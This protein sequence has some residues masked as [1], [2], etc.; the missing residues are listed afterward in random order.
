MLIKILP[1]PFTVAKIPHSAPIPEGE[2]VF[3]GRT[4]DEYS[5]LCP[6]S[7]VPTDT[8][9]REDG[10]RGMR[11]AGQLDFSLIGIL[12]KIS[13]V[14]AQAKI[15]IFA[16]STFDTDYIFV[17]EENLPQA[18]AALLRA[19]YDLRADGVEIGG[20]RV[21]DLDA[22]MELVRAVRGNFP[23]LET[24]DALEEHRQTVL[25]FIRRGSAFCARADGRIVGVLLFSPKRNQ[26]CCMAVDPAYR[27]RGIAQ[28]MFHRMLAAA[29]PM[30]KITVTT[31]R[32]GDPLGVAPRAFYEKNGFTPGALCEEFGYPV[33][34][35]IRPAERK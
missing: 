18:E 35:Y 30:E 34:E 9:V 19:G 3:T 16:V 1:L 5:L 23:G 17:K 26:L 6:T 21:D 31:F 13:A 11:I 14:L 33:Q 12:A 15:G 4:D 20:G 29:D 28:A 22:W 25:K 2:F 7:S 24:E 32:A 27:R 10:W 8:L